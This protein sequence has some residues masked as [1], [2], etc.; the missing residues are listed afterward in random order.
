MD[1]QTVM[2]HGMKIVVT[3]IMENVE[4]RNSSVWEVGVFLNIGS[5]MELKIVLRLW[6][7]LSSGS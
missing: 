7:P 4:P 1:M 5:V 6:L 2:M 3:R